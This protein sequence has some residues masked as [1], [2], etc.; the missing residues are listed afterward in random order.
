MTNYGNPQTIEDVPKITLMGID[1]RIEILSMHKALTRLDH[2]ET[3][4][5]FEPE[6]GR[7]FMYSEAEFMDEV[8]KDQ[9]VDACG[10]SGTSIMF[11]WTICRFIA[12]NGWEKFTNKYL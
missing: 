5:N 12:K 1:F 9:D 3:L 8:A 4:K 10:H 7:G 11:C 2:W 6:K